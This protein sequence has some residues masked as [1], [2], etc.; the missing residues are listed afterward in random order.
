MTPEPQIAKVEDELPEL[1]EFREGLVSYA[2]YSAENPYA[3]RFEH[4]IQETDV[5][6]GAEELYRIL[7]YTRRGQTLP[8][9]YNTMQQEAKQRQ[10]FLFSL[11]EYFDKRLLTASQIYRKWADTYR[12]K[13]MELNKAVLKEKRFTMTDLQRIQAQRLAEKYM[14]YSIEFM[15]KS[16]SLFAVSKEA[17][18]DVQR[19]VAEKKLKQ[20]LRLQALANN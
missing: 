16:D 18:R 14:A 5:S 2:D 17:K 15:E 9:D 3:V 11:N 8:A 6:S 4:I 1:R 20:H 7:N 13:A 19:T 10:Q 12:L